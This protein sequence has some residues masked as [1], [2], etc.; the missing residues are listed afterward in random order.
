MNSAKNATN[1]QQYKKQ[2]SQGTMQKYN[3]QRTIQEIKL[4]GNN[5]RNTNHK[6][7]CKNTSYS[8]Q[9]KIKTYRE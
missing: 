3:L 5:K 1:K 9:Y 8:E 6:K 2:Q 4:T 7:Q